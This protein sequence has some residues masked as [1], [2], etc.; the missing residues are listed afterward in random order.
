MDEPQYKT[1][2]SPTESATNTSAFQYRRFLRK[3]GPTKLVF[4]A[5]LVVLA[6]AGLVV[7]NILVQ[8]QTIAPKAFTGANVNPQR[9]LE[10]VKEAPSDITIVLDKTNE[11]QVKK[12]FKQLTE[13]YVGQGDTETQQIDEASVRVK[14]VAYLKYEPIIQRTFVWARV[15]NLPA[16][17]NRVV[18]LWI[19]KDGTSYSNVGT[20]VF[21]QENS[22]LIAYS[23]FVHPE[24]LRTYKNLVFSYDTPQPTVIVESQPEDIVLTVDF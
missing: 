6:I 1:A 3:I 21:V 9:I 14:G 4:G 20:V 2:S 17:N 10:K 16:P 7:A 11:T 19:T 22:V 12:I 24:D 15:E 18:H 13:K 8:Q 23:V 5:I